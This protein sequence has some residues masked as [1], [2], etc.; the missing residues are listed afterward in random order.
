[1]VVV[2]TQYCFEVGEGVDWSGESVLRAVEYH[3]EQAR[4]ASRAT[5][6]RRRRAT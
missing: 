6:C 5:G 1:L 4:I 3:R 2:A